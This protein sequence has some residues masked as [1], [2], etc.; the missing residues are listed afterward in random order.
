MR[1]H[2][3]ALAASERIRHVT[4]HD[5]RADTVIT[6]LVDQSGSM[7]GQ[8]MLLAA[9]ATDIAQEFLA[10][11]G[12]RIEILGFTTVSWK[13]GH[14]RKFWRW[15]FRPKAPGRLCEL[16]HIIYR[17]ADDNQAVRL[18]WGIRHMLRPDLPKE[19][20]DGEALIWASE[21][22]TI[23]PEKRKIIIV[24]SDG[25]PADDSTLDANEPDILDA[26][27]REV[28]AGIEAKGNIELF[29][30]GIGFDVK[31]YYTACT[32][33]QT[34][35]DLGTSLIGLLEGALTGRRS[36]ELSDENA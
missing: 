2:L 34:A 19:N 15:W 28:I 17:S 3:D 6:L 26:H 35:Q 10:H 23:R 5:D 1:V 25:A 29:A 22:L 18:G 21:R 27:L 8:S 9:A 33:I 13:G 11:L 4:T 20:I 12:Y 30:L 16:L 14:P 31:R 36:P 7:R 24:I 32:T